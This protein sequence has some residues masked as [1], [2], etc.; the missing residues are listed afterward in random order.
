M[1]IAP[2]CSIFFSKKKEDQSDDGSFPNLDVRIHD[3][4]RRCTATRRRC[5]V[6]CWSQ[7][8]RWIGGPASFS[9]GD[10]FFCLV[11]FVFLILVLLILF[12][13]S[14]TLFTLLFQIVVLIS[15]IFVPLLWYLNLFCIRRQERPSPSPSKCAFASFRARAADSDSR[16]FKGNSHCSNLRKSFQCL[17]RSFK[18]R[19][20]FKLRNSFQFVY[21]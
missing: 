20:R 12:V 5:E 7:A 19:N 9:T 11:W 10:D 8:R 14:H 4:A 18:L 16:V 6:S 17:F 2:L 13:F 1:W 15:S 3:E 21:L